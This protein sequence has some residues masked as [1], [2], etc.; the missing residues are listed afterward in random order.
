MILV[1]RASEILVRGWRVVSWK[2]IRLRP[3]RRKKRRRQ[4][5][6]FVRILRCE[7]GDG[8]TY[9]AISALLA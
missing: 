8:K 5:C 9:R 2:A 6:V 3:E 1:A 7:I 4:Y